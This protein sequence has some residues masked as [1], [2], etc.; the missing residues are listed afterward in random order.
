MTTTIS[1]GSLSTY[2]T[3]TIEITPVNT[4]PTLTGIPATF[5]VTED[6]ASNL[7]CIP[8]HRPLGNQSRAR[9]RMYAELS[10]LRHTM[11]RVPLYEPNGAET[12]D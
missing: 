7:H 11:N 5:T 12:F 9:R 1:D 8:E 2:T 10:A 3:S 6:I 4:A